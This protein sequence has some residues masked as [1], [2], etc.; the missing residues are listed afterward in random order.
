MNKEEL[1]GWL[2]T[3]NPYTQLYMGVKRDNYNELWSGDK[4][5]VIYGITEEALELKIKHLEE[6][7][8]VDKL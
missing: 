8:L 1:Y 4:G 5:N 6:K 7:N 3:F 2:I